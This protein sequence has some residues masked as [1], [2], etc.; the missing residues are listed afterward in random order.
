MSKQVRNSM[1]IGLYGLRKYVE[2]RK[3]EIPAK[4]TGDIAD[5]NDE[6]FLVGSMQVCVAILEDYA[7]GKLDKRGV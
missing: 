5:R 2:K 3:D 6:E 4:F 1:A 7:D